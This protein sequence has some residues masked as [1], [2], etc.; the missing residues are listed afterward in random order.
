MATPRIAVA[1]PVPAER[2]AFLEWLASA[3]YEPVPMLGLDAIVRESDR[4]FEA[5]IADFDLVVRA[6]A[7]PFI[8]MLGPNRPLIV[9]G[10]ES[11]AVP[12][13]KQRKGSTYLA[14][15]VNREVALLSLSL[16][17]SEG[18]PARRSVRHPVA[19][20]PATVDGVPSRILDVSDEG[21]RLEI[22]ED[23]R[24]SLP[25]FF[26]VR[27]PIFRVGVL[28]QR[29]WVSAPLGATGPDAAWCGVALKK[30]VGSTMEAW[31]TFLDHAPASVQFTGELRDSA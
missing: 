18:R 3:G 26:T 29:V 5:L 24:S 2:A 31:R 21:I 23:H 4:G 7:A 12:I 11:G 19:R 9:I 14:R 16:A 20:I 17:L 13:D 28:V 27:V 25:P 6:D 1:C 8:R 15:P 22:A 10:D 30:N